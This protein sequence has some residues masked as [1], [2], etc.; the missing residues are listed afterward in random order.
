[1]L[2]FVANFAPIIARSIIVSES[3]S[4]ADIWQFIR[5]HFNIETSGAHFCR[6]SKIIKAP[7]ETPNDLYQ[8][9]FAFVQDNLLKIGSPVQ[10]QGK[11]NV[12][13][14]SMQPTPRTFITFFW[15]FMLHR[16]LPSLVAQR[17]ADLLATKNLAAARSTIAK[18]I[19]EMLVELSEE[20]PKTCNKVQFK[21]GK[22]QQHFTPVNKRDQR[23]QRPQRDA[24]SRPNPNTFCA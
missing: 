11:E 2:G 8:R 17:F 4:L 7:G 18:A 5:D 13:D 12:K 20:E 9:M 16:D 6:L 19:P 10:H 15:M 1:M 24:Q 23:S 14:E 3:C 21:S 22:P